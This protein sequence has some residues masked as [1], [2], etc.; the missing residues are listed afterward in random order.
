MKLQTTLAACLLFCAATAFAQAPQAIDEAT[1]DTALIDLNQPQRSQSLHLVTGRALV[2]KLRTPLKRV[3][4]GEPSMLQSFMPTPEELVLT[5]KAAG[6]SS[7]VLWD[8]TGKTYNYTVSA[9][10]DFDGTRAALHAAFPASALAVE[11]RDGRLFL[12][13]TVASQG[14][15]DAAFKLAQTYAHDV[16][17]GIQ[18]Q[19]AQLA[20]PRQVQLK[21][22][23]VEVDR[24]RAEQF[25]FNFLTAGGRTASSASTGQFSSTVDTSGVSTGTG[26]SVSDP[27]NLFLYNYKLNLG[28]T[29]KD[30]ESR[31]IL[32]VLAE[33]TLTTIS[34]VPARF[35]SGGEIPVPVV[36]GGSG[37]GT[38]ISIVYQPYGVKV[39]FTP[40]VNPDGTIR[41]KVSPEV[42]SLDY[43]NSVTISGTTIPAL[44]TRRADTEVEIRDGESFVVSGILDHRTTNALASIPGISSIPILGQLFR[45]KNINH[46]VVELVVMVTATVVDPL[47]RPPTITEPAMIVP[48]LDNTRF[49]H[50]VSALLKSDI[51]ANTPPAPSPLFIEVCAVHSE[52]EADLMVSALSRKGFAATIQHADHAPELH[53]SAGPYASAAAA[54]TARR[55]LLADGFHAGQAIEHRTNEGQAR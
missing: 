42:S 27:L 28:I 1:A 12:S 3:Y 44:A 25:G 6:T 35:L 53:V 31:Q 20:H 18:V 45:S 10:A 7:L 40:T 41:L 50:G 38:A 21:L 26:V 36:Q 9:D 29:L 4:I 14:T 52:A 19:S 34:G 47:T 32:Q 23:I 8:T 55:Q 16:V 30:A 51:A 2:L 37:N 54:E 33:P 11:S 5:A 13:G 22:R 15:A 48:N 24:T 39:D 46:S 17:N 43:T 49:D